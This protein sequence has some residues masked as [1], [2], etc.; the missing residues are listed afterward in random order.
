[1]TSILRTKNLSQYQKQTC[2]YKILGI[3]H[4]SQFFKG[5]R[6]LK[7]VYT[8]PKLGLASPKIFKT[9]YTSTKLGSASPKIKGYDSAI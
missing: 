4:I 1:M 7:I 2:N 8:S 9:V 5:L 6:N 3:L